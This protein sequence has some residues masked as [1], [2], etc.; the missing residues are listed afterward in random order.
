[1]KTRRRAVIDA[2]IFSLSYYA[3]WFGTI[4]LAAKQQGS[5]ACALMTLI[6]LLQMI[7]FY[8][9]GSRYRL[10]SLLLA[11][12]LGF[13]VDSLLQYL[14]F[15]HFSAN[16]WLPLAPPWIMALWFNFMVAIAIH[17]HLA[18]QYLSVI[19]WLTLGSFP[20]TYICGQ[21]LGAVSFTYGL[22][23][24]LLLGILWWLLLPIPIRLLHH[25]SE[26]NS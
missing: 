22:F 21:T 12:L 11:S 2:L 9:R 1:M 13:T 7:Y 14:N 20:L 23:S 25:R 5:A 6:T 16:P 19:R 8:R 10:S 24:S 18:H 26:K 3:A 4:M 15:F 17:H